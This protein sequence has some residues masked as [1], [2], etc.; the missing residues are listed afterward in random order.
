MKKVFIE[1][2]GCR[3]NLCDSEV[4]L[5]ILAGHGYEHTRT[6]EEAD[7]VIVN[8]CS[9]RE[10]GHVK[11]FQRIADLEKVMK[12]QTV[13]IV[14]GC[15]ATQLDDSFFVAYPYVQIVVRPTAYR[16]IPEAVDAVADGRVEHL[17]LT[18]E[19]GDEVYDR[20]L[21]L[22]ALEDSVTAAVT[23]MK[24]C[25]RYCSYCIEPY[26]RGGRVNR[27]YEGIM[28]EVAD[29]R[30]KGYREITLFGHIV[31]LWEGRCD[32]VTKD[33]AGLLSDIAEACP[34]QRIKFISSHPLTFSDS[35]AHVMARHPN[36]MKV[37]H[38]PVQSGSDRIL[39][40][41]NRKDTAE[42]FVDRVEALRRIVPG[43]N[44]VTDIMVGFPGEDETDFRATLDMLLDVRLTHVNV[45][46]FSMRK[47]TPAHRLFS[48]NV[49]IDVKERRRSEVVALVD[50]LRGE[51]ARA[52]A[53]TRQTVVA[54]SCGAV[55]GLW[56]GR[57]M[58]HR[59]ICFKPSP[60]MNLGDRAD[61]IVTNVD[62]GKLI[63]EPVL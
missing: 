35:I 11:A 27:S 38:L 61:I 2:Y 8:G 25:D 5:S 45:F 16:H 43:I 34:E 37:V 54:E 31:D 14:A 53:G 20:Q 22:R 32:G 9:V 13:L 3:M 17:L 46:M 19:R 51:A 23:I 52:L 56:S 49:P 15:L 33:F 29:I 57:D 36:V 48:D 62:G 12:P 24:G 21:P 26:T 40:D 18:G 6:V 7:C 28:A 1:T 47:G 60:G 30:E 55:D 63:G 10:I 50:K 4:I 59:T 44:I 41:M 42:R 58:Y 39:R